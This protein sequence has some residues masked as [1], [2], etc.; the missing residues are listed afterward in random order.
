MHTINKKAVA[1]A[2]ALACSLPVYAQ[3]NDQQDS[4]SKDVEQQNSGLEIISVTA[5]KRKTKLMETPVAITALTEAELKKNGVNNIKDIAN[6]VPSLDI[7]TATDQSAPVI[8]MRGVRST[9][10]TEL[11]DPAVGVHLDGIYSPRMQGALALMYDI[12][13]VEALRGPQG[14][15]FGRNSTVGSINVISA[16]P[17]FENQYGQLNIEAGKFNSRSIDGLI[18]IPVT[19]E[20]AVRFSAKGLKRDSYLEGYY[21]PNQY[22]TRRL[23]DEVLNAPVISEDS[24]QGVGQ[25]VTQRENW[26]IDGA[27]TDP[28]AQKVRQLT[29][30]DKSDFYNNADE[31]SFRISTLWEPLDG[32]FSNHTVFQKYVNDSNNNLDLVNC[33]KLR[34]RPAEMG[35]DCTNFL[36][37]DNTYQAVVNVPGKLNLDITYLRNTFNYTINDQYGS[38]TS[39][40]D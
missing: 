25:T 40:C 28:E 15:L 4:K 19:E 24:Y 7:S 1:I 13:R 6:L 38:S 26:W 33:D 27:G 22:D 9:N 34:G 35:G 21:D 3:N 30:A 23:S 18:N 11:G 12:D 29:A 37:S 32:N 10:L 31:Y 8:S 17:E 36:P 39:G 2:V 16:K 14:T 20:F 5:T